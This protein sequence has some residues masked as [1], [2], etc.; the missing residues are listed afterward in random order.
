MTVTIYGIKNCDTMK[1]ARAWLDNFD[2]YNPTL[3]DQAVAGSQVGNFDRFDFSDANLGQADLA[4]DQIRSGR[5]TTFTGSTMVGREI[6]I[7]CAPKLT[8]LVAR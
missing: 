8:V 1:K 4:Q 6:S 7:A 5:S 2:P 3:R